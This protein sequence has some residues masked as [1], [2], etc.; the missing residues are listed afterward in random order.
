MSIAWLE[1]IL[2]Y[3]S[4]SLELKNSRCAKFN[5]E[6][7]KKQEI[8]SN[9]FNYKENI[10]LNTTCTTHI[11]KLVYHAKS[12]SRVIGDNLKSNHELVFIVF[13]EFYQFYS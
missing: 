12:T 11:T 9:Q 6:K 8:I 13:E 7:L 1:R 5:L 4:Q 3:H 2:Y 10:P